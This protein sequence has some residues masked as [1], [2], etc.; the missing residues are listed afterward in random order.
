V[1]RPRD[2]DR[3]GTAVVVLAVSARQLL[4]AGEPLR[5]GVRHR[6]HPRR[7]AR[8]PLVLAANHIG[9]VDPF[10]VAVA[11]HKIGVMPRIMVTGG[12]LSTPVVGPLLERTGAIRVERGTDLARHA[13][14][15]TEVAL[16]SGGHV[17]AYPEGRVG[18][19]PDGWPERGCTGMA[20]G[21]PSAWVCG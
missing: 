14:R 12:I 11:L 9:D 2:G 18:L 8:R 13:V 7:I 6:R 16:V 1:V 4:L 20:R 21:W 15:V 3:G 10:V 19:A 17:V 5:P